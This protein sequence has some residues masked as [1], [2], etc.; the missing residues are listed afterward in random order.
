MTDFNKTFNP[1]D[2]DNN[3]INVVNE[4]PLGSNLKIEY[5]RDTC[6]FQIDR[7]EPMIFAKPVNYGFIPQTLDGDGDELDVL[8]YCEQ[9]IPTGVHLTAK[10]IGILNFQD[11][12]EIDH[13][14]V[15]VPSD[16]RDTGNN[17]NRLEDLGKK[18]MEQIE[19]HFNHYKDLKKPGTTQVLGWGNT[20]EAKLIIK[21]CIQ[22]YTSKQ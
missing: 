18:W 9:P 4:I 2:I 11:D 16:N 17:I 21:E 6:T 5:R 12:G 10:I 3:T 22:R 7:I 8:L 1:G 20:E 19:Y 14:V 15:A 13:K